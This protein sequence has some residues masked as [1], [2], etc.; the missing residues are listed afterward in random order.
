MKLSWSRVWRDSVGSIICYGILGLF[1]LSVVAPVYWLISSSFKLPVDILSV[2]PKW[3]GFSATW[4][5]YEQV[6]S[7][8]GTQPIINSLVVTAGAVVIALAFGSPAAYALARQ[9]SR[10]TRILG[11][12]M[13]GT[14]FL[15]TI[16]FILP[17]FLMFTGLGLTGTRFG[18]MLAYQVMLLPIVMYTM[19]SFFLGIPTEVE[20]A[21][22]LD[23]LGSIGVVFRISIPMV[24]NGLLATTM[25]CVI[26]AWNQFFVAL[27][28]AG[29]DSRVVTM[30]L[31]QF[32]AT[33][34][35][36]MAWGALYA[37]TTII[38]VPILIFGLLT[39]TFLLKAIGGSSEGVE[40]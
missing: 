8:Y 11:A 17:M 26:F 14:R 28:L 12:A 19:W 29:R 23:G 30:V 32:K 35:S 16:A 4:A 15:P 24:A 10:G 27:I 21:A 37:W 7:T 1:L 25:M 5:N 31:Q 9:R 6:F 18:L 34:D 40:E 2:P 39:S 33:E 38:T 22:R 13:F 3:V 36:A 20:E